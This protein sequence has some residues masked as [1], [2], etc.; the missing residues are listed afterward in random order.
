ML[1]DLLTKCCGRPKDTMPTKSKSVTASLMFRK[2][3]IPL[4]KCGRCSSKI[5]ADHI[6]CRGCFS[7]DLCIDCARKSIYCSDDTHDWVLRS[8]KNGDW[9]DVNEIPPGIARRVPTLKGDTK[10]YPL[11][12]EP[13][14]PTDRPEY[15]YST[16]DDRFIRH[17]D[18]R[19]ILVY[20]DG[21]CLRSAKDT[22][23]GCAIVFRAPEFADDSVVT[24]TGA[25]FFP[26]ELCGPDGLIYPQ[27]SNRAELRAVVAALQYLDW[28]SDHDE[29]WRS[30]VIATDSDYVYVGATE[31]LAQWECSG[32]RN[33]GGKVIRDQDLW[34][35]LLR[36][37]RLL[38]DR[39]VRVSFWSIP[40]EWNDRADTSARL[41]TNRDPKKEFHTV[42]PSMRGDVD[43]VFR[44]YGY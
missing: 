9:E 32:W 6:H 3:N 44:R 37:I 16:L 36:E 1:K 20:T 29:K 22:Q 2:D 26:L 27:T 33:A 21:A 13:P 42:E 15:L 11:K 40:K 19:E 18:P 43:V 25:V 24:Q 23:G 41:A 14:K 31:C 10:T 34:N 8:L 38:H 7:F 17:S 4:L 39:G 35:V 12:F 5:A 30:L 28:S